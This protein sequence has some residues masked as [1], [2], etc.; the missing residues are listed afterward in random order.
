MYMVSF[1][2]HHGEFESAEQLDQHLQA[3]IEKGENP[4]GFAT[5]IPTDQSSV[6]EARIL[7]DGSF[8]VV[9]HECASWA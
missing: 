5:I 6:D 4:A 9:P 8:E 7:L 2:Q 1:P 3:C